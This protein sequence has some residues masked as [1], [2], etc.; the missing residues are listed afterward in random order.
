MR[1]EP[2]E[3]IIW[4][5]AGFRLDG[6][7][8]Y[9]EFYCLVL[10]A[11]KDAPLMVNGRIALFLDRERAE[12]IILHYGAGLQY[13]WADVDNVFYRCD[14]ASALHVLSVGAY[15]DT[16]VIIEVVNLLLDLI[17]C[18]TVPTPVRFK[19]VLY[20]AADHFTFSKDVCGF[21]AAQGGDRDEVINAV[22]WCVGAIA[23]SCV[24]LDP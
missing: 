16:R 5:L 21:F 23:V 14:I 11:D 6:D 24:F 1:K 3:E 9:P 15:D 2:G 12:E 17:R 4:R 18:V 22:L 20:R 10:E 19:E 7:K 13:D 8:D